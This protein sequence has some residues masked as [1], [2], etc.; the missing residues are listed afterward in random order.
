ML[1]ARV[2]WYIVLENFWSS[3]RAS[4]F[5]ALEN[6]LEPY[7]IRSGHETLRGSLFSEI[8]LSLMASI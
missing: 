1:R 6:F 8:F 5:I 3:A 4:Q 2:Y 7:V